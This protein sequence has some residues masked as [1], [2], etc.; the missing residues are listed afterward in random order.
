MTKLGYVFNKLLMTHLISLIIFAIIYYNFFGNIDKY[1][2]THKVSNNEDR[3][4][5]S[6]FYSTKF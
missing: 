5:N 2:I 3:I 4:T 6:L 1:F